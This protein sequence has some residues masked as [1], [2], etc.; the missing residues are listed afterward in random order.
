MINRKNIRFK[1]WTRSLSFILLPAILLTTPL[2]RAKPA[3]DLSFEEIR[4]QTFI[5]SS[6]NFNPLPPNAGKGI[7]VAILSEGIS[8]SMEKKLSD[9]LTAYSVLAEDSSP[10]MEADSIMGSSITTQMTSLI[11]ALAPQARILAVKV[12]DN[13]GGGSF[14]DIKNGI[15]RAVELGAKIIVLPIS[16]PNDDSGVARAVDLAL[17]KGVLIVAAAGNSY[18]YGA[19][20]PAR[21]EGVVAIGAVDTN[22][23]VAAFSNYGGNIIFA[24]GVNIKVAGQS[25]GKSGTSH[26][27]GVAGAI[28]AIL[29]SQN[30]GLSR[31]QLFDAVLKTAKDISDSKGNPAKRINGQAALQAI[32][33]L[34]P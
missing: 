16:A 31:Q 9:Q 33:N 1:P 18:R 27:A 10:Y 7:T 15:T 13:S 29:W 34:T 25:D 5:A 12:L 23:K 6:Y 3:G 21:M 28:F 19:D 14:E 24:P 32:K 11:H 20:F 26:A 8:R 22:D 30:P 2:A 4:Q 17:A